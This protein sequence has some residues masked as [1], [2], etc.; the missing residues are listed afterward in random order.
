MPNNM[1]KFTLCKAG[2]FNFAAEI[3]LAGVCGVFGDSGAGKTSLVRALIGLDEQFIG[4]VNFNNNVWQDDKHFVKTEHRQI[5]M[6]FQ[7]PRLF[8]HLDALGNLTL[9][10]NKRSLYTIETLAK[11][12]DF[13]NLLDKK[14]IAL[15]GGQKQ[16]IAIARAILTAPQLLIMDEPLSSLDAHSRAL[17][18]P[19]IKRLAKQIPI[20]YITHSMQELFYLANNMLLINDGKIEAVGDPQKLFIDP[21]LSLV[22]HAHSGLLLNVTCLSWDETHAMLQGKVDGQAIY[23][24]MDKPVEQEILQ[25]KVESKDVIIATQ[26]FPHSSLQNCFTSEVEQ[27][28]Q[29]SASHI[30]LTLNLGKQKLLAKITAKSLQQLQLKV[31][32]S[33]YSYI[34]AVS[35]IG[36]IT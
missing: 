15:S 6:V 35:I 21:R 19:F 12:L 31:G 4:S 11:L 7:E 1:L 13:E 36:E 23:L 3:N 34:K 17:L 9:A 26:Q 5:G 18:L 28:E 10:H 29:I 8:P 30:L 24:A 14:T 2:L 32:Q 22:K 33:V 25:I 27:I 20:L 16:R